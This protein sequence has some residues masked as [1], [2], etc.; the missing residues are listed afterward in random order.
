MSDGDV[1]KITEFEWNEQVIVPAGDGAPAQWKQLGKLTVGE[2]KRRADWLVAEADLRMKRARRY[3]EIIEEVRKSVSAS[4]L[5][6][7]QSC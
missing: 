2:F 1:F 4:T 6:C 5:T 3:C 7:F